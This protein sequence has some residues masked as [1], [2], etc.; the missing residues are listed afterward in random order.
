MIKDIRIRLSLPNA[1]FEFPFS[2]G[3]EK[4]ALKSIVVLPITNG[5]LVMDCHKKYT[6]GLRAQS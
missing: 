3:V 5:L 6:T 2:S 4:T 1:R